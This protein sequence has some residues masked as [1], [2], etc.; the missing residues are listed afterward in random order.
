M[1]KKVIFGRTIILQK[2]EL[3]DPKL[4]EIKAVIKTDRIRSYEYQR[5][6]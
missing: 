5:F 4:L 2:R 3:V 6:I 1:G